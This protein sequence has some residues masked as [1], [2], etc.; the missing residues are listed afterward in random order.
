M[1]ALKYLPNKNKNECPYCKSKLKK[2]NYEIYCSYCGLV[3][4]DFTPPTLA[5][6]DY[7][8]RLINNISD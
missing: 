3:L 8:I 4:F 2:D 1:N 6:I 7:I 5:E